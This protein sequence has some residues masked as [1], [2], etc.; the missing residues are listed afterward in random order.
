[1]LARCHAAAGASVRGTI[2]RISV[3]PPETEEIR[4]LD[5]D[6]AKN[7]FAGVG[8]TRT[9]MAYALEQDIHGFNVESEPEL[10]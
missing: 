9:E 7:I 10:D 4:N 3:V 1:M 6:Q 5:P 8:K 2:I